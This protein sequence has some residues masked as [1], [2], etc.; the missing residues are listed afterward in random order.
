MENKT[1]WKWEVDRNKPAE[2]L[3]K[4]VR[5]ELNPTEQKELIVRLLI[6]LKEPLDLLDEYADMIAM[7]EENGGHLE[8]TRVQCWEMVKEKPQS[9][10]SEVKQR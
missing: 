7:L 8:A 10:L 3:A 4:K 5:F 6:H 9:Y 2:D 1:G